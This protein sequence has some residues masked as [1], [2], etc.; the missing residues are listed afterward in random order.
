MDKQ[1]SGEIESGLTMDPIDVTH[2]D[3]LE[4][5]NIAYQPEIDASSQDNQAVLDQ[6]RA[7]DDHKK[8]LQKIKAQ[9]KPKLASASKPAKTTK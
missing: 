1:M 6:Q 3:T 2:M 5:Q 4:R 7:D 9:P 8:E